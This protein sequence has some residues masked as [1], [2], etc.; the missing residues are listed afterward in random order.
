MTTAIVTLEGEQSSPDVCSSM[1]RILEVSSLGRRKTL[2]LSAIPVLVT[3][4]VT[5]MNDMCFS[6]ASDMRLIGMYPSVVD[7][8]CSS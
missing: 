2:R 6:K 7:A 1:F 8:L 3:I 4:L 5:R